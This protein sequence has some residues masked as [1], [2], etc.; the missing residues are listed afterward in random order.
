MIF[1]SGYNIEANYI[2]KGKDKTQQ[3]PTKIKLNRN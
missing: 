1:S 3:A 2:K